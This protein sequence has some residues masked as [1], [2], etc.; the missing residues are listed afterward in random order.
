M[1]TTDD[2]KEAAFFQED[3]PADDERARDHRSMFAPG[4]SRRREMHAASGAAHVFASPGRGSFCDSFSSASARS[5]M[6][7][8][9]AAAAASSVVATAAAAT[10]NRNASLSVGRDTST[11]AT[12]VAS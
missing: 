1:A 9:A 6:N 11:P 4:P 5:N 7:H 3:E 8:A 12:D 10:S 2:K